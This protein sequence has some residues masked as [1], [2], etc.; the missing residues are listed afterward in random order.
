MNKVK[1]GREE[2]P[3]RKPV[4]QFPPEIQGKR[5]S[6]LRDKSWSSKIHVSMATSIHVLV[7]IVL[8]S[9]CLRLTRVDWL[10][11]G[12]GWEIKL[13]SSDFGVLM[14]LLLVVE[15]YAHTEEA[16]VQLESSRSR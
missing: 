16:G 6:T 3:C 2:G 4:L 15:S 10:A 9:H 7:G 14:Q 1:P 13:H 8:L 11:N 12:S 5:P